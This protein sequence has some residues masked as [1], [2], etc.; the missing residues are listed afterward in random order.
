MRRDQ[1]SRSSNATFRT[2]STPLPVFADTGLSPATNYYY[3][4]S[5]VTAAN[6]EGALSPPLTVR[7]SADNTSPP[8]P[9]HE[10]AALKMIAHRVHTQSFV[11]AYQKVLK[12]GACILLLAYIPTF[13]MKPRKGP[14]SKAALDA[15]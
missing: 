9:V 12:L 3:R 6:L 5:A 15:H 1:D 2:S 7:T 4:V 14:P 10:L 11:L 8:A 13:L